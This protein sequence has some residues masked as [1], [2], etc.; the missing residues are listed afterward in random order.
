MEQGTTRRLIKSEQ[1]ESYHI[2]VT[3]SP[4]LV[5]LK[6]LKGTLRIFSVVV[7]SSAKKVGC[8]GMA[9]NV[10]WEKCCTAWSFVVG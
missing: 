1:M 7:Q 8:G 6:D 10:N 2:C 9:R 3:A 5:I 4:T